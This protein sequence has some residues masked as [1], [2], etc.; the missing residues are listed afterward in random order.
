MTGNCPEW[1][2]KPT[3]Q[4]HSDERRH[5]NGEGHDHREGPDNNNGVVHAGGRGA[6]EKRL[7]RRRLRAPAPVLPPPSSH[8]LS[9]ASGRFIRGAD[10]RPNVVQEANQQPKQIAC[11]DDSD[12]APGPVH[13]GQGVESV[14]DEEF[15]RVLQIHLGGHRDEHLRHG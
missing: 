8:G 11:G 5:R 14:L 3:D 13:D 10:Y 6:G 7:H 15:G 9:V 12:E 4:R 1:A 2:L